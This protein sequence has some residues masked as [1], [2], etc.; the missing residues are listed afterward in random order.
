MAASPLKA[1]ILL[2]LGDV[3]SVP[4][5]LR[6][7]TYCLGCCW[8]LC[9]V[10]AA[11]AVMSL[12]WMLL[13]TLVVFA[14]KVLPHGR[15]TAVATVIVLIVLGAVVSLGAILLHVTGMVVLMLIR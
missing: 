10:L 4:M 15:I 14:E 8:A 9:A 7:G 6:H 1:D 11:A 12:A 3:S 5:G 13:L 2:R